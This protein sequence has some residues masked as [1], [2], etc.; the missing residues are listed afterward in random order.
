VSSAGGRVAIVVVG[1][2]GT[3][4]GVVLGAA[5]SITICHFFHSVQLAL[6]H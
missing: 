6:L 1:N 5:V 3:Q 4:T 2:V